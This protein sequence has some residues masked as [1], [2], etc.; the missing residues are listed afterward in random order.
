M[1]IIANKS[2][3]IEPNMFDSNADQIPAQ[4]KNPPIVNKNDICIFFI[5]K[6]NLSYQLILVVQKPFQSHQILNWPLFVLHQMFRFEKEK[7]K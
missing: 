6:V 3:K 1:L 5:F 2:N 7:P 4:R